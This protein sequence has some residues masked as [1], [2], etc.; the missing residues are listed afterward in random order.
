MAMEIPAS[1]QWVEPLLGIQK[2]P[3]LVSSQG[4]KLYLGEH[5]E[6]Y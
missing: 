3:G 4:G 5:L 2:G 1:V 6:G